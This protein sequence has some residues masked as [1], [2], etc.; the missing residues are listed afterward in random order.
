MKLYTA[1]F[2]TENSDL[3]LIPISTDRDG[4]EITTQ[5]N[6]GEKGSRFGDLLLLFRSMAEAKGWDVAEGPCA[7]GFPPGGRIVRSVYEDI[8]TMILDDL[9]QAMPVDGVLLELHGAS[10]AH[11][12]DDC[13]GD[14]LEHI[15]AITGPDI[16]IGVELDPHCHMSDKMMQHATAMILYK[17]FAHTDIKE[18]AIEL[19]NLIADTL[20]EKIKPV[21]SLFDCRMIDGFMDAENPVVKAFLDTVYEG[22]NR[23]GIL[24]IS[25]V[26]GF[27]SADIADMGSKM[28]VI[29]DDDPDLAEKTAEEFGMAFFETR[30]HLLTCGTIDQ[31]LDEA[32]Q[33]AAEGRQITFVDWADSAGGGFLTDGTEVLEAM[34][35][36]G[37]TDVA[38]GIMW[39]PQNVSICHDVGPDAELMLRIGGKYSVGSGTPL[40][41]KVV[42][43]RIYKDVVISN[44]MDEDIPCNAAV[45]R[46]GDIE[47][48]LVSKRVLPTGLQALRDLGVEP[49]DKQYLVLKYAGGTADEDE[50]GREGRH[51]VFLSGARLDYKTWPTENISRPKWPWDENP[52]SGA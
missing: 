34:L 23:E 38:V 12:Y 27:P 37:M 52:F 32:Q 8:R 2:V 13:E 24:S 4:W 1:A 36:R 16:P 45:V 26:H 49:A 9:Q 21:M 28:L 42:V 7:V 22:E 5:G 33:K 35:K 50:K 3:H 47:I 11:G 51:A 6:Y 29:A 43:E 25:P 17:T 30:G 20:E 31:G 15:R 44:W 46:S 14:L 39:D 40:D 41:L 48:C 10:L 19:F 18:R